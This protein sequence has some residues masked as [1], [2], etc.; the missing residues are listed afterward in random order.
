M[1][2]PKPAEKIQ[3]LVLFTF[4][5]LISIG[6]KVYLQYLLFLNAEM[7]QVIEILPH[8]REVTVYPT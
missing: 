2:T 6:E 3:C 4:V 8:R 7:A 1:T 5:V